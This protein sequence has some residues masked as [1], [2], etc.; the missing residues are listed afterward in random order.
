[1]C[2]CVLTTCMFTSHWILGAQV[3]QKMV[4]GPLELELQMAGN[5][6]WIL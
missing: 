1:M 6:T 5:Q 4:L 3:G 2:I